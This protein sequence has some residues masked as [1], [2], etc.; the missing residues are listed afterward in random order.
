[1]SNKKSEL[2]LFEGYGLEWEYMIVDAISLDVRPVA[3][4]LFKSVTGDF[5]SEYINNKFA[6]SNELVNHVVEIKTNGPRSNVKNLASEVHENVR[7][8]NAELEA[9][10]ARLM[11][12]AMHPWMNPFKETKLWPHEFSEIY[13]LYNKIFDC[14]GHGWS[15]LQSLHIN[16]PFQGDAEFAKLHAAIRLV[17]PILPAIAASSP[18][19][20]GHKT[21]YFDS[22]LEAYRQNQARIPS[23]T[24]K[25]IPERVFSRADYQAVIFDP[26]LQDIKSYDT[27]HILDRHFLN[28]RG[29]IARFDRNAI[30]IRLLDI[31]ECPRADVAVFVAVTSVLKLMILERWAD[32]ST[33]KEFSEDELLPILLQTIHDGEFA[34]IKHPA[35]L[36][37]FGLEKDEATA[38]ELWQH[39]FEVFKPALFDHHVEDLKHILEQG[40]LSTRMLKHVGKVDRSGLYNLYDRLTDCLSNNTLL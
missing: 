3:D 29:A 35:Y 18:F 2:H 21:G 16:L 10:G 38:A 36:R 14:K 39:L 11:P 4:E 7:E 30:E 5:D 34:V 31:Q 40:S 9:F 32:F 13:Q 22:R 26:I 37:A 17:L 33:Q 24:G 1:M 8:I 27:D 28:S 25:V 19:I 20:E 12:T 15:N 23:L 6:W